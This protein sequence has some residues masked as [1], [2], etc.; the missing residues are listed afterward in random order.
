MRITSLILIAALT[1]PLTAA[2]EPVVAADPDASEDAPSHW[3]HA[4]RL[5]AFYTSVVT[6]RASSS[7]DPT[8][9]GA[10][11]ST[12]YVLTFD[13]SLRW[14]DGSESADHD[15]R[16][17]YGK[18]RQEG[19]QWLEND[20]E[21]RYEGVY[22]HEFRKPHFI[23]ASWGARSVFTNPIDDRALDPLLAHVGGGYGQLY[24]NLLFAPDRLE[25]RLGA[26]AQK[27]WS[28]HEP[29]NRTLV[30]S[31]IEAFLRYERVLNE[32]LKYF[33]QYDG[34][35]EFNDLA[36]V[37]NL[38]TAGLTMQLSKY[39]AVDV[40]LRAYYET[41]PEESDGAP[42]YNHWSVRQDTLA[43]LTVTF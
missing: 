10:S 24:E 41:A 31:G 39:L 6:E 29:R 8:I 42:V 7:N 12:A 32:S 5:G 37:T 27:R 19:Q 21:A 22:R 1:T 40:G 34:F 36:H 25:W 16:L 23:Y 38:I 14:K 15:L 11:E 2:E 26:R 17:R 4:G 13:G 18:I 9:A 3:T 20:D 30:E 43:G 28:R 33:V 35:S